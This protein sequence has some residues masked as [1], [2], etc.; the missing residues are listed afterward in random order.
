MGMDL[1]S[2]D[3]SLLSSA[4][5]PPPECFAGRY[6][7]SKAAELA[8][9]ALRPLE[10]YVTSDSTPGLVLSVSPQG[11]VT[12]GSTVDVQ[13]ATPPVAGGGSAGPPGSPPG[14]HHPKPP[15]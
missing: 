7:L 12:V 10:S 5:A 14:H 6:R 1:K 11:S 9:S 13:V 8:A 2:P 15:H 4:P 3:A